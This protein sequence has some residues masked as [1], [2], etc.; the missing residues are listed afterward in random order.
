[1]NGHGVNQFIDERPL[2]RF[3]GCL[4]QALDVEVLEKPGDLLVAF[5]DIISMSDLSGRPTLLLLNGINL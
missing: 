5:S 1:M 4:P 3:G 2:L